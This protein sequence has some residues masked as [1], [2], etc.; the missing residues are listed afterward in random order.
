MVLG[1]WHEI[2]E[3]FLYY[4]S[5]QAA[6]YDIMLDQSDWPEELQNEAASSYKISVSFAEEEARTSFVGGKWS[7]GFETNVHYDDTF[8]YAVEE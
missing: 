5:N 8:E 4:L 6:E 1:P 3:A 7:N 2:W